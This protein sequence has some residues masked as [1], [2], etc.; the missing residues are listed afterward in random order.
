MPEEKKIAGWKRIWILVYQANDGKFY[1]C[2][3][4]IFGQRNVAEH[5]M[6]ER[7]RRIEG[8]GLSRYRVMCYEASR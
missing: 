7:N 2:G 4:E 3:N 8:D 1:P 6:R 5:K